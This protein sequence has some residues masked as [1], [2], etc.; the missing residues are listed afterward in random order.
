MRCP[1]VRNLGDEL[2]LV[3]GYRGDINTDEKRSI[4]LPG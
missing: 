4:S 3:L 1:E 2:L